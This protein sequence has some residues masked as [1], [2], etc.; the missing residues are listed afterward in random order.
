MIVHIPIVVV[1]AKA[2]DRGSE[3]LVRLSGGLDSVLCCVESH[4][5]QARTMLC[6]GRDNSCVLGTVSLVVLG[7][8]DKHGLRHCVVVL[9]MMK[10]S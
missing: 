5:V 1:F 10:G 2:I 9:P 8:C 6:S 4:I 3:H 7:C